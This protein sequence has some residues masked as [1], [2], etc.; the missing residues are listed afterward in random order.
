VLLSSSALTGFAQYRQ[1]ERPDVFAQWRVVHAGGTAGA[2]QLLALA[3]VW[4]RFSAGLG[5]TLVAFG[6]LVATL[7]F[8]IGPLARVLDWPR[9]ATVVLRLGGLV[10]L[11]SYLALPIIVLL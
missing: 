8:F 4:S 6:V 5:A 10:A 9:A 7:A 1:R 2:V 3:A 11:P